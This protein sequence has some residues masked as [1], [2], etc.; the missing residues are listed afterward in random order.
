MLAPTRYRASF[1][2]LAFPFIVFALFYTHRESL[3]S[4]QELLHTQLNPNE[5]PAAL[6]DSASIHESKLEST[7]PEH[8]S[9]PVVN[10]NPILFDESSAPQPIYTAPVAPSASDSSPG[11]HTQSISNFLPH[12]TLSTS[13]P[14]PLSSF[15]PT[16]PPCLALSPLAADTVIILKTGST[17]IASKFPIHTTTTLRCYPHSLIFSD[18]AETFHNFTI[19]D[20]L[21]SVSPAIQATH[22]DFQLW[23][24]LRAHG[25][26]A[27]D[28]T[29]LAGP[30][31]MADPNGTGHNDNPGWKLDKWKFLPMLA[32]T[33][34]LHPHQKW[35]IFVE[36]DTYLF[37][38]SALSHLSS[39]PNPSTEKVY[40]GADTLIGDT[41]FNHGGS[42]FAI[43]HAAMHAVVEL[44]QSEQAH[45]ELV[46]DNHW[47]GDAVLG[48][49]MAKAGVQ[50]TGAAPTWQ[51][52]SI[53]AVEF[54]EEEGR[55]RWCAP[56]VSFHHL[57]A[58]EVREMWEFEQRWI[59]LAHK[60]GMRWED[61][62]RGY[63]LPRTGEVREG[64]ENVSPSSSNSQETVGIQ[65]LAACGR[66]CE[67]D[68]SCV[69]YT[70]IPTKGRPIEGRC[71]TSSSPRLGSAKEGS[72]AGWIKSRME[73]F[74][75]RM[76]KCEGEI[77]WP[78]TQRWREALMMW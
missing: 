5:P 47:A 27:L 72:Q 35:Y 14:S 57:S 29:E 11:S 61:V 33:Y 73:A 60:G 75:G 7:R 24:R 56:T 21:A 9:L 64:W 22:P 25:R 43:S 46:T 44:Y 3:V 30:G 48:L 55:G 76:P 58:E 67:Q 26:E 36:T 45:W 19:L 40:I 49:A 8:S 54:G 31:G 59:L 53:G 39:L 63:I 20:A 65:D 66:V 12:S 51:E 10:P 2:L 37:L 52:R 15:N 23:R 50:V 17:E 1:L 28:G 70:F 34:S 4:V 74:A 6:Y 62:Y 78:G 18:H 68:G 77:L 13:T 42:G 71:V 38:Q 69:Q 41:H 32:S 16:S